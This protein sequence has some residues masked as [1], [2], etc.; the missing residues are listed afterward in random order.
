MNRSTAA[1]MTLICLLARRLPIAVAGMTLAF[2]AGSS[3]SA[4]R[5]VRIVDP[6]GQPVEGVSLE[7]VDRPLGAFGEAHVPLIATSDAQGL[8]DLDSIQQ[9]PL[10]FRS[11]SPDWAVRYVHGHR[12]TDDAASADLL[13]I[14]PRVFDLAQDIICVVEPKGTIRI[15]IEGA[16]ENQQ[17]H[18]TFIDMRPEPESHRNVLASGSFKGGTGSI[19]VPAGRGT[20][21]LAQQGFL[22]AP[23]LMREGA[24]MVS[25]APGGVTD[26]TVRFVE[27]PMTRLLAPFDAIPFERMQA[28][29]PDGS[30]VVAELPFE[31]SPLRIGSRI[32]I[33]TTGARAPSELPPLRL[34]K[35]FLRAVDVPLELPA[36]ADPE[37][38]GG[39]VRYIDRAPMELIFP[40][41]PGS[42][43]RLPEVVG[44]WI[45][46]AQAGLSMLSSSFYGQQME[47][48]IEHPTAGRVQ[49]S[50]AGSGALWQA[51]ITVRDAAGTPRPYAEVLVSVPGSQLARSITGPDGTVRVEGIRADSVAVGL[52]ESVADHV[53]LARPE[54][55][56]NAID[57]EIRVGQRVELKGTWKRSPG[58]AS[59]GDLIV[60]VPA[61]EEEMN[62]R[63]RFMTRAAPLTFLDAKGAFDFGTIPAGLYTL[64]AGR[65]SE[66]TLD[67]RSDE[68]LSRKAI[69]VLSGTGAAFEAA[70]ESKD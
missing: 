57:G 46:R 29:A 28:L 19:R 53:L 54:G 41:D 27:G 67:L 14:K 16:L 65:D 47:T 70:L 23:V 2:C 44:G 4:A 33:I 8:I 1:P 36:M 35:H 24:L 21:Y 15:R 55:E 49:V 34:P 31:A 11:A 51:V 30:T 40:I 64:R 58:S 43:V 69:L 17:L 18:A 3:A 38:S 12:M 42:K 68:G 60:L 50:G 10:D 26:V 5:D 6:M 7:L 13:G 66:A 32:A 48:G 39:A 20:L 61:S 52:V 25:V 63:R 45:Q 37:S 59:V 22:G 56:G 9:A 62:D